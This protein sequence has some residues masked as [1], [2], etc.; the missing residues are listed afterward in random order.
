[1]SARVTAIGI[2]PRTQTA[3]S[4][5]E[6]S[7]EDVLKMLQAG[8]III[9]A[10]RDQCRELAGRHINYTYAVALGMTTPLVDPGPITRIARTLGMP[11]D[12]NPNAVVNAV[13]RLQERASTPLDVVLHCPACKLQHIDG[14]EDSG[15]TNKPH[16]TH[17]CHGCG[18][19][20][21]AADT[22]TNGVRAVKPG[23]SA[24]WPAPDLTRFVASCLPARRPDG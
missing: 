19:L 13:G 12:S 6:H 1:M 18:E 10:T 5:G 3:V 23:S 22:N 15:W 24:T 16:R 9:P 2:D 14:Y 8:E 4:Y 17:K 7:A 20:W 11:A 21:T